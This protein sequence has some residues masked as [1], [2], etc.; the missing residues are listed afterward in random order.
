MKKIAVMTSGGD[1]PGMNS[2]IRA[3]VRAG[4]HSKL[5]VYGIQSG[6][7][8][9]IEDKI[10]LMQHNDV[11]NILSRGG[12]ILHTARS[13]EFKTER[14]QEKAIENLR[15][16]EIEALIVIG[17]DGSLTGAKLLQD[18]YGIKCIGIPGSI[19]NDLYGTELSLGVDTALNVITNSIDMINNTASS[20]GRTFII[21]VMGRNCGYLAV[22]AGIVTGA[23]AV[24]IPERP[25]DIDRIIGMF[26]R[27]YK[28][29]KTRNIL[30][31]AEGA[32]RAE[33]FAIKLAEGGDFDARI[34]I[35]GHIQ[36]GG[37]PTYKDR[38]LGSRM[39]VA[40]IEAIVDGKSGYM[41][42]LQQDKIVLVDFEEVFSKKSLVQQEII[43]MFQKLV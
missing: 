39:G 4:N 18:K 12:T 11:S 36:R 40:A 33:D 10:K 19:D 32:G 31:I 15:K 2:A 8:G 1:S 9:L 7:A 17:G 43:D 27:R 5:D 6:Y 22:A 3:V 23:D 26:M 25:H 34:T 28:E 38:M 24:I 29:G 42:G 37:V 35:L 41:T 16:Y 30:I 21:E 20:H 13:A 14:G